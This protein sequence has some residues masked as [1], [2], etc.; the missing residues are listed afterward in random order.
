VAWSGGTSIDGAW[1][2]ALASGSMGLRLKFERP[3]D[4][5]AALYSL[6]QDN[7]PIEGRITVSTPERIRIEVRNI[8]VR[9]SGR[10]VTPDRIEDVWS[11]GPDLPLTLLRG[12]AGRVAAAHEVSPLGS[13]SKSMSATL[14]ARLVEAG[15]VNR[16]DRVGDSLKAVAPDRHEQYR[17]ATFRHLLSHR[18]GIPGD[19]PL[20]QFGVYYQ[21]GSS[22]SV[23]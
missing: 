6:D 17:T 15:A 5:R 1:T 9:F 22:D 14:V 21:R 20:T 11:Q 7:R 18:S 8:K 2:G 3:A 23:A 13:M 19:L 12:E 10:L 4:G 16:E